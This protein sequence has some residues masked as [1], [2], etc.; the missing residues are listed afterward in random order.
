MSPVNP[1]SDLDTSTFALTP[2]VIITP[3]FCNPTLTPHLHQTHDIRL[4]PPQQQ[5]TAPRPGRAYRQPLNIDLHSSYGQT[6]LV[7]KDTDIRIFFQNVKGLTYTAS[8]EDYEYYLT[9]I[10]SLGIDLVGMAE[11]NTA[12]THP[13]LRSLLRSR[14][15]KHY[16]AAKISFSS[17]S[18]EIDPIPEKETFQSGGTVTMSTNALVP[19]AFGSDIQDPT[20]LGRWSGQTFRGKNGK[21]FSVITAYRVCTGSIS[22]SPLGSAFSREY[23]HLRSIGIKAPRPRK[24]ILRDLQLVIIDLQAKGTSVLLMLDSNAQ[25]Q[26][27]GD[28]QSLLSACDLHDL[29]QASPSPSTYLGSA[30]RRID[31]M[32]GCSNTVNSMSGSGSLSYLEGP[33]SDHRGLFVDLDHL[34]LFGHQAPVSTISPVSSR[35][36]RTGNPETVQFY[37][38][39]MH[40]YYSDHNMFSRMEAISN[41]SDTMSTAELRHQLEQWDKDQGRAMQHAEDSLSKSAKPYAWS[42]T[43]RDAGLVCR[44]WRMR[45]KENTH[46]FNF[47]ATFDRMEQLARQ[48]NPTFA[49]PLRTDTALTTSA[50]KAHLLAAGKHLK[51]CQ[52][53]SSELRFSSYIDLLAVY[54]NDTN[55]DTHKESNRRAKVVR[56]TIRSEQCRSMYQSIKR[57]VKPETF[58]GINRILAPRH[59]QAQEPTTNVPTLLATVAEEDIIWDSLLDR[60][61]IERNLLRYNQQSFRAASASPCGNG[62]IHQKLTFSSLS[63]EAAELL[64]GEVPASW[65]GN[66]ELLREFL[67]S[68]AIPDKVKAERPI[69]T[70]ITEDDVKYGFKK[71]KESTSTS[72]SGRHLGHYKAIVQDDRLLRSMTQFLATVV[73]HGLTMTRWCNAVNIMIEKDPGT[74]KIT[75]LRIIHL[76][77]ADFNFFLKLLWGS[78]LVKR[79]AK[80]DLLNDGQHG[81]VPR[82]TALDPIMLTQLTTDLCRLLRHNHARFDND[83]SAC[84]DRIIVALGMLAARRCGMPDC[85]VQTHADSLQLMKYTVKTA[86]GISE[87]N[88]HGTLFSPLFGTGQGSGASPAVWLTM[89][90]VLMNTLDRMIPE[91]MQFESPDTILRHS[92]LIDA[93][94]DDTSLGFTDPGFMTLDTMVTKLNHMAQT[95]EQLL[96]YSG[97]ALNLSKC[98]W[99]IMYWDWHLGRPYTRAI[100]P[101]DAPTVS[102]T[103]QGN[104]S[105]TPT[106]IK[107]LP[108]DKA[109]RILGVHL[110]PNGNFSAQLQVLK[111]KADTLSIRLRSPKLTPQDIQTFHRTMY[112]P[113][114]KY[115]LPALAVDEEELQ[116]IQSKI[117]PVILQKL[118]YSSKLPTEIR[119]GP[120]EMGGLNLMDLRTEIGISTIKYMRNAIYSGSETGNLMILNVKYSQIEAGISENILEHTEV[121]LPYLTPTW[122][123]SIRQFLFQHSMQISL[124][125]TLIVHMRSLQDQCIMAPASLSRYS[126]AQQTDINLVRLHLQVITISDMSQ[127]DGKQICPFHLRGERRPNQYI[128]VKTWPRQAIPTSSQRTL[129][130][131]YVS[132]QFL[133]YSGKWRN[134]LGPITKHKALSQQLTLPSPSTTDTTLAEYI[135]SLPKWYQRLL[136]NFHQ[137]ATDVEVWRSFRA[138]KRLVISSDGSLL[139][140]TGTF[141][142]KITTD[143]HFPLFEGSGPIDGPAEIGSSTRSELGGFTAPLLLVTVLAKHWGLKHRCSFRWLADSQVAINRVTLVTRKDYRPTTQPDNCDYLS[144]IKELFRE[145]RR[146]LQAQWIKSHQD[147]SSPYEKLSADAK[148]NVDADKLATDF[149]SMRR[150]KPLTQTEHLHSTAIS[151]MILKTRFY[152]NIDTNIRY[153]INGSYM[154]AYLQRRHSWTEHVW[155]TIDI[156]AFGR[157]FKQISLAH[158]PAH[159]KFVHN[160]LPLGDRKFLCSPIKDMNLKTCPCCLITNEDPPHFLHCDK[161]S[162]R[163]LAIATFLKSILK[164]PHPSRLAFAVSMELYLQHPEQPVNPLLPN[165]PPHMKQT[166][167]DALSEQTKIGWIP[168]LQGFLSKQWSVLASMSLLTQTKLDPSAGRSRTHQAL[169]ATATLTRSLWLGRNDALHKAQETVDSLAYNAESAELR[170][171]HAN[172]HLLPVSDQHYTATS[173]SRLLTSRPSVRRRWLRRVRTAR[174]SFLRDGNQ[175]RSITTYMHRTARPPRLPTTAPPTVSTTVHLRTV[176]TQQ[177]MTRFFPGRP[178]DPPTTRLPGNP[179][180]SYSL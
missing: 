155:N 148:L 111:D 3:D 54:D 131:T 45:L 153:H 81:S 72:P 103:T 143:K 59:R 44:Y 34:S 58:G 171:Y 73:K 57:V 28:L 88:Y 139:E 61:T 124:T 133:R 112:M 83:A 97:G 123:T 114:M 31:H 105:G 82:R 51:T 163:T 156:T 85:A 167:A 90:V 38:Q 76:F 37:H 60:E 29:H 78:R 173:L 71:W 160:Q 21:S 170:R 99:Y 152:G 39:A 6:H 7:R 121:H 8:G 108:L 177:R 33:Q 25:L 19:M 95:W 113:A 2:E 64:S 87:E 129:W 110:S 35:N 102:L 74:P 63:R 118:G 138:R 26:D 43:L 79:A 17:P 49:L 161:N 120:I 32:F 180:L 30:T 66:D 70:A 4:P 75:R 47:S 22:T 96:F 24:V 68:F 62:R 172:P 165:F 145:L 151:V 67:T 158:R 91:R 174:A 134:P 11:T 115:V 27:D 20:G 154:K 166:L 10:R 150:A 101:D 146:P 119:H 157:H 93:F 125:D 169:K 132:T 128:R 104:H 12:W 159:L 179:S 175:Q 1:R 147:S 136:Y 94:V 65:H 40:Q 116:P 164:D 56:T 84:Y 46:N 149:H 16:H 140:D 77:E 126:S 18:H 100:S 117:I 178:P 109:S 162:E 5:H 135:Q 9:S 42:P 142:W 106:V 13:H 130:R 92:R 98:S 80:L 141:G 23:E 176:T 69:S 144:L 41:N 48:N 127:P 36:L 52:R 14:A 55:P 137:L 107:R 168:A 122:I 89:V 86:H 53:N 50:V 15:G